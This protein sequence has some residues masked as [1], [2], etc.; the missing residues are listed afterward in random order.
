MTAAMMMATAA[1]ATMMTETRV[2]P[3][4]ESTRFSARLRILGWLLLTTAIGL[5]ALVVTVNSTLQAEAARQANDNITQELQEFRQFVDHGV[6]PDTG[7]PFTSFERMVETFISQQRAGTGEVML[8]VSGGN[9]TVGNLVG[10]RTPDP[11]VHDLSKDTGLLNRAMGESSGIK[12][13]PAGELRWGAIQVQTNTGETGYLL[14]A[15]YT[16]GA[17]EEV[18][19]TTWV[20]A[21]VAVGVLVLMAL[22]GWV[23]AGRILA[24]IRDMRKTAEQISQEDLSRRIP[25]RGQD[26]LAELAN[27]FNQMLDR[28][29]NAFATEQRFVDDAGHE[30]RTPIT[31][32]R[33]H[34]ELLSDDPGERRATIALVTGE[35]DRM[36]R[37]VSDLLSLAKAERPDFIRA[38]RHVDVTTL[39]L[40]IDA[41]VQALA[42]RRWVL[43]GV[44]EGAADLDPQRVTQAMLQLAHNAVQ[45]TGEGSQIRIASDFTEEFGIP[46][47]RF[48]VSDDGPGVS[49]NDAQRIFERFGRGSTER[50]SGGAGLG[51]AIVRAIADGH[52]GWVYVDSVVGHGATF[53]IVLPVRSAL[54][55]QGDTVAVTTRKGESR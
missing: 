16:Q 44:A 21:W 37:I 13:T 40:D 5:T 15:H 24:P 42:N 38:E 22:I 48:A 30:L 46:A 49:P 19:H 35:L 32:V 3:A 43:S 28:L 45:H 31:I 34:L 36:S 53:G 20:I 55:A 25:V 41:K 23:V 29:E 33:G 2:L 9:R 52:Q 10:T 1:A 54:D 8:G 51:L 7:Q 27:T 14:V 47:V 11:S 6:D 18:Q 39:T 17:Y 26:D 4:H 50:N 12:S